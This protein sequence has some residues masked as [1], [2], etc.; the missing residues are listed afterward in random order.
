MRWWSRWEVYN[1][2]LEYFGDVHRFL[3][4]NEDIAPRIMDHLRVLMD[5]N[6]SLCR[7]KLK[8]AAMVD[9]GRHFVTATYDLEG[10]GALSLCC[11]DRLQ[12]VANACRPHAMSLPNVHAVAL[13]LA[14]TL[15][16]TGLGRRIWTPGSS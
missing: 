14:A 1:Q 11:Y 6:D 2:L 4:S 9:I 13:D 8:L 5:D 12:S 15:C 7:L 16:C 3:K 10:D